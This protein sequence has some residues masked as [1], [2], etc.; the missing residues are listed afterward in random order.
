MQ[1]LALGPVKRLIGVNIDG[2]LVAG[3]PGAHY[4]EFVS[5]DDLARLVSW[6]FNH[7]RLPVEAALLDDGDGWKRL[8]EAIARCARQGLDVVL[9]LRWPDHAALFAAADAWR[10]LAERW[11]MVTE[12]Y[13]AAGDAGAG[14]LFDLLDAPQP[15][16]EI[17]EEVLAAL[18][19]PRL[20]AAAARRAPVAG[21]T[22]GRAWSALALRLTQAI[23]EVAEGPALVVEAVGARPEAF[24]HVRPTRDARTVYS[25]HA[26]TPEALTRRGEGTYPGEVDGERWDRERVQQT[27][28]PALAFARAYEVTLYVGAFGITAR[29]ATMRS[30]RS[31]TPASPAAPPHG[32]D[33]WR[34]SRLTWTRSFL[35]LCRGAGIGWAY[36]T[37]RHPEFGLVV[38]GAV[39]YDLLGVLQS[40]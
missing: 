23:R 16:A 5:D 35:S 17:G 39:D 9:A 8:D 25:F 21:A 14:V 20:S 6:R 28:E 2:W 1:A 10:P 30:L 40:E 31:R 15:P 26:F 33:A 12:R 7:V 32:V 38:E 18:G 27:L 36:W 29:P 34:Q 4:R 13:G 3:A 37:L 24:T 19:A 11:R 22:E